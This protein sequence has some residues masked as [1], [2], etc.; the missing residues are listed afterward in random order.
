MTVDQGLLRVYSDRTYTHTTMVRHQGTALAFAMDD[1]RRIVYTVLDLSVHDEERGELDA[2]YWSENP[3]ALP[4]PDEIVQVGYAVA[5]ATVMPVV[6]RGGRLEA[7]ADEVLEAEERDGFLS[8]TARLTAAAPFQVLSDGTHVVVLR[9][10]IGPGHADAVY[11]LLSGRGSSGDSGRADVVK[12]VAGVA[13]PVVADTLLCDRFLLVGGRLKPV[14]EVRFKRSRHKTEPASAKDSLGAVDM[15]GKP[16][17]EPTQELAFIANLTQGRFAAVLVPTAVQGQQ[18]WQFFA[19]NNVT[20]RIDSFSVEQAADGLFNTQGSRFWTSPDPL[21]QGSVFERAA[22]VCPFTDRPLVPVV[23]DGRHGESALQLNGTNAYADLGTATALKFQGRAYAVEAWVKPQAA[24]GPVVARWTSAGQ[25]GFRLRVTGTG[26]VVLDHSGGSVTSNRTVSAGTWAHV[27]ASFDGKA[28]T[29]YV[30]GVFAGSAEIAYAGDGSA[31]LRIGSAQGGG[32]F[33]GEIDEVRIWKRVRSQLETAD[34]SGFRLIGNEPGLLAYYR[35]DEAAGTT[36]YDQSDTAAHGTLSGGA[37]WVTSTAPVGDH[38]GVRR[39]SFTLSGREVVS[40]LSAALYYQQEDASSG[41]GEAVKPAK[42]QARVLLALATR[43][44]GNATAEGNAAAVDFGVGIDGRLADIPDV[45]ALESIDVPTGDATAAITAQEGRIAQLDAEAVA[46]RDES[47]TLSQELATLQAQIVQDSSAAESDPGQWALRLSHNDGSCIGVETE[48]GTGHRS[49][50]AFAGATDQWQLFPIPSAPASQFGTPVCALVHLS[51]GLV[52]EMY[53]PGEYPFARLVSRPLDATLPATARWYTDSWPYSTRLVNADGWGRRWHGS[54]QLVGPD[55]GW[56]TY[57]HKVGVVPGAALKAKMDRVAVLPGLIEQC[58]LS[59]AAKEL[60]LRL[61]REELARLSGGRLGADDLV[62]PMPHVALD[63]N[64]LSCTG[65]VLGFARTDATPFLVDSAAGRVALYYRGS[66]SGFFAAYLDTRAA[67]GSQ[68]LVGTDLTTLFTARDPGIGLAGTEIRVADS[69][70]GGTAAAKLCDLTITRTGGSRT[71]TERFTGVPRRAEDFTAVVNGANETP[72]KLGAVERTSGSEVTLIRALTAPVPAASYVRIGSVVHLVTTAAA[73]GTTLLRLAQ[74]P[75]AG[76]ARDTAVT[77]VRYDTGRATTTRPGAVLSA[78]SNWVLA[79]A[80][81]ADRTVG[82]GVAVVEAAGHGSRWRGDSPGRAFT[83]NGTAHRLSLPP[84]RLGQITTTGGDL[85]AEAWVRPVT[86]PTAGARIVHVN[87]DTTRAALALAGE[88]VTGGMVMSGNVA[89]L[90]AGFDPTATDFTIECWL[91]RTTGRTVADTI[92]AIGAN[93]LTMGFT[94]DGKFRFGFG[95]GSS[96]QT[97]TTAGAYTDGDWHHWAVTFD[98]TARAQTIL[99]DG[100]E[101]ARRTATAVP[102]GTGQLIVGRSDSGTIGFFSGQ[103]AELRTW[104]TARSA[105]DILADRYRRI[106]PATAGLTGAW[107]YDRNRLGIAYAESQ[108]LFADISG[109]GRHGGVWGTSPAVCDSPAITHYRVQAAVGDKYRTSREIYPCGEWAHL[110]AVYEQSWALR[111][112]GGAWAE[113]PHEDRLDVT[114]DLTIE[115][116]AS[117]DSTAGRQGLVSK[118][119]LGDGTGDSVPYQ[120]SLLAGGK[121]EF[122]FEEPG[123]TTV[124]YTS[125]STLTTG[126]HRIAVV[127]KAG[128][129]TKEVKQPRTFRTTGADGQP[130]TETAEV[131]ERVDVEEWYDIRFVVD[132]QDFGSFRHNGPGPRGNDGP[133]EIGRAREGTTAHGLTGTIGEVRIW[134]RARDTDRIGIPV[135]PRDEGLLARWTFEENTGNTTADPVGGHDLKLRRARWTTDPDPQASSFVLHRNGRPIPCDTPATNPLTGWGDEQLTLGAAVTSGAPGGFYN[136]TLEEVRLWRTP[137]SPEQL[138][139]NLFTRLKGDKQDLIAYWPFD[140]ESTSLTAD[141]VRDHSLRGNHLDPGT[142]ITRPNIVLSTAPVSTDTAAVRSALASV[143]TPFHERITQPPAATEYADLQYTPDGQARGVLKRAY[144]HIT[145][146]AWTLTTGYKVG[147]LTSEWVSQI[148]F[149]PQLIGYI[150]GA[151]PVPSENLTGTSDPSGASSVTFT[152]ADEITSVLGSARDRNVAMSFKA[153]AEVSGKFGASSVTAPL[154]LG[155][156][157]PIFTIDVKGKVSNTTDFSNTWTNETTV[158]QA[159]TVDRNTTA[160]LTGYWE[161]PTG[162]RN[163]TVGRRYLP[164][165][166]GYA[167]VQSETADVY[168]L[169]LAHTGDLVAYRMVPNPDVPKDWNI[170]SFPIY[171]QYTKQGILDGA[172]GLTDQGG[173]ILDEAYPTAAG[174]GEYSYFKPRE[175]YAIKRRI[176]RERQELENFYAGVSTETS[177]PD[178]TAKRAAKVLEALTGTPAKLPEPQPSG[179][180]SA[181]AFA[182]RSIANTYVWTAD[183]GFFAETTGTV[184]IVNET[185]A[186]SYTFTNQTTGS[187]D[188]AFD[189]GGFGAAYQIEASLTGGFSTTRRRSQES[190]RAHTL[191]VLCKPGRDLQKYKADGT[192]EYVNGKPVLVP[193]KV[194]AYRFMTFYLGQDTA[195]FDDFYRKVIDPTWL[196]NSNDANAA[197]LRQARQSDRK[198]PCWRIL[199]RVTFLSR[200]LPPIPATAPPSLAK[201]LRSLDVQSNYELIRRLDPYLSTATGSLADLADATRA[202]LADHLPELL[203]HTADITRFLAAY[204]GTTD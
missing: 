41:Y 116:F 137:R 46:L 28:A 85:T 82:N 42:R 33:S 47:R 23:P 134:G 107:I 64:G 189:A 167:L 1:Q 204:Y 103:L 166:K 57:M 159:T 95:S 66:G 93:G 158:S 59:L 123:A 7:A 174:Y 102:S 87:R 97:L 22:G 49:L 202:A 83:F 71:E 184:D 113:T 135:K 32:F 131:T 45:V 183:G 96:A 88:P 6:K 112:E 139:D 55:Q 121:L 12:T 31:G 13:V 147:D 157:N 194:D 132:G 110:A 30:N 70:F 77:L 163:T 101:V 39:D 136:G 114:G 58:A 172:I 11:P 10:A 25:P 69:T 164:E 185:T 74:A 152:E 63:A 53:Y 179:D 90:I 50:R 192:P 144:A 151:P 37:V 54:G 105:A 127:R 34:E 153:S 177:A 173:K 186:G 129:A 108:L 109:Q 98:R 76:I 5:G 188:I 140:S 199:H 61:A 24:G 195:H 161:D 201:T 191:E 160:D 128:R 9:Q 3:A 84:A 142:D 125:A 16:F 67:R 44:T 115:V 150:E 162:V 2:A 73:E 148:Q 181:G 197:A 65:A 175:A 38:P 8:S 165:N 182:N 27:A 35:L 62:L 60:D 52:A 15:D 36:V 18:R 180:D 193:G 133:L 196:A 169:R 178:P 72:L 187:L 48:P 117:I 156:S 106:P 51:S 29:L 21:Y 200:V 56:S 120:L 176:L 141:A 104:S 17:H 170:I 145:D 155:I 130:K 43:P 138:L 124:R 68:Q 149:D 126:F 118:G 122:A 92:V 4:F 80:D 111:F 168:A 40:G 79:T 20:G 203:P 75:G 89:M 143:R 81:H 99:R 171:P 14:S 86:V 94:D 198:P 190:S 19:H 91:Q 146:G 119:A 100:V 154:G 78:G 26:S